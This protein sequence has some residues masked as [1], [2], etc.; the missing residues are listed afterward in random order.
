MKIILMLVLLLLIQ[1]SGAKACSCVDRGGSE[2]QKIAAAYQQDAL[3]FV[4]RV[5]GVETI[6]TTDTVQ[7]SDR[8]PVEQRIRLI[9]RETLR[10]TLAVA[11]QFKGQPSGPIVFVSTETQG[12]ACGIRFNVGS[13]QLV[14]AFQVSEKASLYGGRPHLLPLILLPA[15]ATAAKNSE[16]SDLPS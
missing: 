11:R 5:T 1:A 16:A 9:R 6:V 15:S 3:I 10:Y 7:V 8:G 12:S 2:K 13:T 4:G 14:Y